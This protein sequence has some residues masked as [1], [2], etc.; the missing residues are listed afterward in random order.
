MRVR[1]HFCTF[2]QRKRDC[3]GPNAGSRKC[4]GLWMLVK[5]CRASFYPQSANLYSREHAYFPGYKAKLGSRQDQGLQQRSSGWPAAKPESAHLC[6][7]FLFFFSQSL[8][9]LLRGASEM[10]RSSFAGGAGSQHQMD[11]FSTYVSQ[12]KFSGT[13]GNAP[14]DL[15]SGASWVPFPARATLEEGLNWRVRDVSLTSCPKQSV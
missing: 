2:E 5:T 8:T 9:S 10:Q 4:L 13:G 12:C 1:A 14:G 7:L 15:S 3:F 11:C 6:F